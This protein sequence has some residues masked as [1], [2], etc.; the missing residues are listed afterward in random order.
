MAGVD[1]PL[2]DEFRLFAESRW[3]RVDDDLTG[4]FAG[5]GILDLSGRTISFGAGWSF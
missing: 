3:D 5:L 1:V 2:G 4:D